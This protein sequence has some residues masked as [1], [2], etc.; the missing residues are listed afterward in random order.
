[1]GG[2]FGEGFG[3]MVTGMGVVFAL[4]ALLVLAVQGMSRLAHAVGG[5]PLAAS[6]PGPAGVDGA[7]TE[8]VAAVTAAVTAYRKGVR[9]RP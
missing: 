9:Q 6:A 1:M 2:V 5:P 4:L 3:L 7:D 8:L